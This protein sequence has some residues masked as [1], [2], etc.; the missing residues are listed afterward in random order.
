[1]S[2]EAARYEDTPETLAKA[3]AVFFTH[4]SPR[5]LAIAA[6]TTVVGRLLLG[7]W[8]IWDLVVVVGLAAWWP[9]QEWLIHVYILHLRPFHLFGRTIDPY[10]PRKHRAHHRDPWRLDLIFIPAGSF[11]YTLPLLLVLWFLAMPTA[12]LACTG[13]AAH[14]L[15]SLH[16]EWVHFFVHTRY[17]PHLAYYQRLRK[18]HR[19]HHFKSERYWYGVSMLG[20]DR[21]LDTCPDQKA[22]AT[23]PTCRDILG[24]DLLAAPEAG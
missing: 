19:L 3:L 21:L 23:S 17:T 15:L 18:S 16:Y 6:A 9:L 8:S 14:M 12:G 22:V 4:P 20:G 7:G 24:R 10:V 11:S 1:M 5:I 13:L 2:G